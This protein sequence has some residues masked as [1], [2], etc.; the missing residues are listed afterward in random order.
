MTYKTNESIGDEKLMNTV[1]D[2]GLDESIALVF[3]FFTPSTRNSILLTPKKVYMYALISGL[4]SID[5][6]N[7]LKTNMLALDSKKKGRT[8][9]KHIGLTKYLDNPFSLVLEGRKGDI[10]VPLSL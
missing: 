3:D 8:S 2:A 7:K 6:R 1:P 10:P 5:G 9:T 4:S